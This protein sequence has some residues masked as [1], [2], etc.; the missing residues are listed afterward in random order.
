VPVGTAE[1]VKTHLDE[2]PA[3]DLASLRFYTVKKGETL[4]TIARKLGV[5]RSD[6]AEANYL[7]VSA[8][9]NAGQQLMVPHEATVL[10]AARTDRPVPVADSRA[11][12][13][14][15]VVPAVASTTS[16]QIRVYYQVKEGDTLAS[17]A[18]AF[19]TT[20]VSLQTWNRIPNSQIRA[21]QRLTIY[22][23]R[24]N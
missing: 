7:K 8:P 17:I 5:K 15:A 9:V 11:I 3:T 19:K 4:T 21:G 2:A 20:V 24:A 6:L 14:D 12:A 22:T 18:K 13:T 10:M 23:V 1:T 16:D